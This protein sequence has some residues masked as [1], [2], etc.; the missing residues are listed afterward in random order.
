MR[1]KEWTSMAR[2]KE[3]INALYENL[4]K[5]RNTKNE[6]NRT[7]GEAVT[8]LN[9]LYLSVGGSELGQ[10][11]LPYRKALITLHTLD[12]YQP[13]NKE[14]IIEALTTLDGF[15]DFLKAGTGGKQNYQQLLEKGKRMG[16]RKELSRD[17]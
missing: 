4:Q 6:L 12:P 8:L 1:D 3:E 2:S 9:G 16:F 17:E 14:E 13:K 5:T 15:G 7:S 10:S 11:F